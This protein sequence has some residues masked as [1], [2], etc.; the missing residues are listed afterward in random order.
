MNMAYYITKPDVPYNVHFYKKG[1]IMTQDSLTLYKL[2]VLYMLN[3]VNFPLTKA[4][5]SDFIL[6]REY[7]NFLTLQQVIAELVDADMITAKTSRN[8]TYLMI[9]S[10]GRETLSFFQNRVNHSIKEEIDGFFD[11]NKLEMRN[12]ES[13]RTDYYKSVSGE[14]E[15]QLEIKEKDVTV[16]KITL[17]VPDEETASAICTNWQKKNEEIYQYLTR[18]LF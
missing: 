16:V 10:E 17:S 2:I 4:Q 12:E 5:V 8:R 14:Y 3:R 9:T 6:E 1:S 15:A 13:I 18:Q 7:T 11:A